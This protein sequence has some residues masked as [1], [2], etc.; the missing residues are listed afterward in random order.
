MTENLIHPTRWTVTEQAIH[1]SRHTE[2]S[3]AAVVL[4]DGVTFEQPVIRVTPAAMCVVVDERMQVLMMRRH[5]FVLDRWMWELP[6]GYL[7]DP[8]EDPAACAAREAEEE[9][10][11]RPGSVEH[12]VSYQPMSGTANAPQ[13]V[14]LGRDPVQV[15]HESTV[16]VNE[17][18]RISWIPLAGAMTFIADNSLGSASVIGLLA[19]R[20]RLGLR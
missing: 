18:E 4:P 13:H 1:T 9:T 16:D 2:L 12:L 6:G 8:A 11:W 20:E 14:F 5:R 7:D 3:I 10:G 19:A 15:A 17:A